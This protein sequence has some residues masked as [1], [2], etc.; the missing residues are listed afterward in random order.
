MN[1]FEDRV[2]K[3]KI[4]SC[5]TTACTK[6]VPLDPR[7]FDC[8]V[9][10]NQDIDQPTATRWWIETISDHS[11]GIFK[12]EISPEF[13]NLAE[14]QAWWDGIME[15]FDLDRLCNQTHPEWKGGESP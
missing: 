11:V 4:C 6:H 1:K 3:R 8:V 10:N 15:L 12:W 14:L 9:Q 13:S 5:E 7:D 2:S